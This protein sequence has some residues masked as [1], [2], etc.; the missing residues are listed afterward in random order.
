MAAIP[1]RSIGQQFEW[2]RGIQSYADANAKAKDDRC[3][4]KWLHLDRQMVRRTDRRDVDMFKL[5]QAGQQAGQQDSRR[6]Q[7]KRRNEQRQS[8]AE[9]GREGE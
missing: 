3:M 1:Q 8:V 4:E 5:Q 9:R 2:F 6:M 7:A